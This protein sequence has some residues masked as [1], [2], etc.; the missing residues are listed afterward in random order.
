MRLQASLG[1]LL[2]VVAAYAVTPYELEL[3]ET[4]PE[5]S[6][7]S[8]I[9]YKADGDY[10]VM[11]VSENNFGDTRP[12]VRCKPLAA[13]LEKD[14]AVL[15]FE[16]R[17]DKAVGNF[18]FTAN[19]AGRKADRTYTKDCVITMPASEKWQTV[20]VSIKAART[21]P[22]YKV[23][24]AEQYFDLG[25]MDLVPTATLELRNIRIEENEVSPRPI[26]LTGTSIN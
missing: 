10:W 15:A 24:M 19:K 16:Y 17:S 25:F 23:G 14:L 18:R 22:I 20:R 1:A 12:T 11:T 21:N 13:E 4:L 26:E 8:K 7:I 2:C 5:K 6:G 9:D 3:E